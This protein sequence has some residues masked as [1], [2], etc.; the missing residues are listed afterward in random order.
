MVASVYE[1]LT[2][3][4]NEFDIGNLL[5]WGLVACTVGIIV[6]LVPELI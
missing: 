4:P 2:N 1:V 5:F 6:L 3:S